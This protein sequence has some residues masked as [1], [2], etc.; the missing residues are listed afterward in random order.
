MEDLPNLLKPLKYRARFHQ[1]CQ[2]SESNK[3]DYVFE[4][5]WRRPEYTGPPIDILNAIESRFQVKS[6]ELTTDNAR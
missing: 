4:V 5:A 1:Q 2:S 6:F 3:S